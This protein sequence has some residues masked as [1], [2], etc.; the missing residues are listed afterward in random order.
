MFWR[1][2]PVQYCLKSKYTTPWK[3]EIYLFR[4]FPKLKIAY[5]NAKIISVSLKL[6]YTPDILGGYGSKVHHQK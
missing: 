3:P 5:F 2:F 6:N 4:D 1:F